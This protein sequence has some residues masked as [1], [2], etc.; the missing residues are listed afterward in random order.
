MALVNTS[1]SKVSINRIIKRLKQIQNSKINY[2]FFRYSL[3]WIKNRANTLLNQRTVG[4]KTSKVRDWD[5]TITENGGKLENK[6]P[7][8]GAIEFGIGIVGQFYKNP[9]AKN[10][11]HIPASENGYQYMMN[12]HSETNWGWTFKLED[13]Q[14]IYTKGYGG[15]SFLYDSFVEYVQKQKYIE[16]YQRALDKVMKGIAVK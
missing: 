12:D 4:F 7:N 1:I 2:W 3:N 5:I 14:Y 16:F 11:P 6:D 15:K 10:D 13:G 8:S 9:K